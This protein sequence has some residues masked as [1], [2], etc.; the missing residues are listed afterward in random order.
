MTTKMQTEAMCARNIQGTS[1]LQRL[2]C[3]YYGPF[4]VG[5]ILISSGNRS[6]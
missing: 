5:L 4:E 1:L 2:I 3:N 6:L